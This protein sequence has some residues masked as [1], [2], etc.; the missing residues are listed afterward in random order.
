MSELGG[1]FHNKYQVILGRFQKHDHE[2]RC[3]ESTVL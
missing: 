1:L 2:Y 3:F